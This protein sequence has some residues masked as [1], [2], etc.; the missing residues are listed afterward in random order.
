MPRPRKRRRV[1]RMPTATFYK[2]QGVPLNQLRGLTL[3][4]DGLEAVR[5]VDAE[6]LD[7]ETAARAMAVSRPTLSRILAEARSTVAR[8]LSNGWALHIDGGDFEISSGQAE[9]NGQG[10]HGRGR[11]HRNGHNRWNNP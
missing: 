9:N 10:R 1:G 7:Q 5:L 4:V 6:G 8:A 3:S 11:G 2:P